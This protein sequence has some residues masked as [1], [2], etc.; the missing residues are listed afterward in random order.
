ML[1]ARS[2]NRSNYCR[3]RQETHHHFID[4]KR[5]GK[6]CPTE[7]WGLVGLAP[8]L[9]EIALAPPMAEIMDINTAGKSFIITL[10]LRRWQSYLLLLY[11]LRRRR[12]STQQHQ[13]GKRRET[14]LPFTFGES[15]FFRRWN[16]QQKKRR[17][18]SENTVT[19]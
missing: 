6:I 14:L 19:K 17:K 10:S 3:R 2:K 8:G 18:N 5:N 16:K 13:Q 4:T 15:D 11:L 7:S 12:Q 9:R 1:F